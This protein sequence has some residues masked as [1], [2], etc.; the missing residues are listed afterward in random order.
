MLEEM[1]RTVNNHLVIRSKKKANLYHFPIS[2]ESSS[3]RKMSIKVVS[4]PWEGKERIVRSQE[5]NLETTTKRTPKT[6]GEFSRNFITEIDKIVRYFS[7]GG[8]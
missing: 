6:G 8:I 5:C 3:V 7:L 1:E 4:L 2:R